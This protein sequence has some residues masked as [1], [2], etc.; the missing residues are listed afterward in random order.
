MAV[1]VAINGFGR[2]GRLVLRA[3]YEA[4][5]GDVE[6]VAVNDLGDVKMNAHLLRFDSTHGRFPGSVE[7]GD[8]WMD[9][10][11]GKIKVCAERDPAQLP[12]K[13]L[14]VDVAME[15]TGLFN[16]RD[17]AAAH[18]AAG[19]KRVLVSAPAEGADLT[20]VYGVNHDALSHNHTVVSNASCTTN[21]LVPVVDV[22][23]RAIGL[24]RGFMT[25]VHAFTGDQRPLDTLHKDPRRARTATASMIPTSTGAARAVGLVLPELKGKLDG[26]A[27]RVP[28]HNVSLIDLTFDA[29][30]PTSKEAVNA[31]AVQ[32]ANG[33]LEGILGV[34]DL[35]LVS[36][37]FNHDP[38]SSI[39]DLTQTQ[40]LDDRFVRVLAWY[41]NE[42]GFSH[43]MLDTAVAMA[44]LG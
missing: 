22:L 1:R 38:R 21:C 3:A 31:A 8:D 30:R 14:G 26:T 4:G 16:K 2:I 36:I 24:E 20:V 5:R 12:W 42:W 37:D 32:A 39:F 41:D 43:R 35:P 7:T 6:F 9:L 29:A 27:I 23:H 40:V 15:C 17:K 34:N 11:G 10:G 25:T 13:D 33:R 18:L 19:A 44:A 28:T